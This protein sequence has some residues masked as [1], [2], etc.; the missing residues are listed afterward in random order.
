MTKSLG[1]YGLTFLAHSVRVGESQTALLT[2]AGLGFCHVFV[3]S[4]V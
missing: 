4:N 3:E 1:A 2:T